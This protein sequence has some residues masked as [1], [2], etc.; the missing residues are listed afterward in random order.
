MSLAP[1]ALFVFNRLAHTQRTVEAL[2]NNN[3]AADSELTI[4]SDGPKKDTDKE[5]ILNLRT[6]ITSV[7]GFKQVTVVER[8]NNMGLAKSIIAGVTEL[9][10]RHGK[11]IVLEDDMVTSP[12]FLKY[13]NEA[14]DLY[15]TEAKV[16]SVAAYRYPVDVTLPETFFLKGADCW[17]W[18]TWKRGWDLFEPDG[19]KLLRELED[20]NLTSS[21]DHDGSYGY[22]RMLRKQISGENDSWAIRWYASAFLR[23]KLT[24]YPGVSLLENIGNDG[25]GTHS[26]KTDAFAVQS[27]LKPILVEKQPI[28]PNEIV[29]KAVQKYFRSTR[30]SIPAMLQRILFKIK[31]KA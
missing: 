6:Y 26:R 17:G 27:A 31:A 2:V 7:Q 15:A 20:G 22:T 24:L 13:M 3:L 21:F 14:L 16:I 8:K 10:A 18:G 29:A 4:F 28:V 1:I 12:Y 23:N 11:I 19:R 5:K 30:R 25:G 9:V